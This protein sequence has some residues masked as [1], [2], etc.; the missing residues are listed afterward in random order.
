[1]DVFLYPWG[2]KWRL[3]LGTAF[4]HVFVAVVVMEQKITAAP[5]CPTAAPL[6]VLGKKNQLILQILFRHLNFYLL[7]SPPFFLFS[8]QPIVLWWKKQTTFPISMRYQL[9][10]YLF[11]ISLQPYFVTGYS[12]NRCYVHAYVS[13]NFTFLSKVISLLFMSFNYRPKTMLTPP[14]LLMRQ[15]RPNNLN[16]LLKVQHNP[17]HAHS[18]HSLPPFMWSISPPRKNC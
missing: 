3:S 11:I 8:N 2:R 1:M 4:H 12:W 13:W 16:I 7:K 5:S 15:L 18:S 9:L 10:L 17:V 14:T 6:P